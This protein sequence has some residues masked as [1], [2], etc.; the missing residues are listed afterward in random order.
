MFLLPKKDD[1]W[2][3]ESKRSIGIHIFLSVI[4][5]CKIC[6]GRLPLILCAGLVFLL[7]WRRVD[8]LSSQIKSISEGSIEYPSLIRIIDSLMILEQVSIGWS[9]YLLVT[10][11]IEHH[12]SLSL[13]DCIALSFLFSQTLFLLLLLI[14]QTFVSFFFTTCVGHGFFLFSVLPRFFAGARTFLVSFIWFDSLTVFSEFHPILMQTSYIIFK[15]IFL[16]IW[17]I[18]FIKLLLSK[19][20]PPEFGTRFEKKGF[21]C[22]VCLENVLFYI[23]LPCGHHFCLNCFCKWGSIQLTCPVCRT[24]F[25][26]WIHQVEFDQLIPIS[27]VIF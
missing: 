4:I 10:Y 15:S 27:L 7:L 6:V 13:I 22:P 25:S 2:R 21:T 16:L 23:T 14:Q 5:V 20:F 12:G 1:I 17:I 9:G 19:D 8:I 24:E 18:D 3:P 11:M 26:S